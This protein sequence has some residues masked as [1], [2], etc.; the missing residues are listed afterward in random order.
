M[1]QARRA[2]IVGAGI[3][4]LAAAAS[5]ARRGWSVRVHE[6]G[7][8]LRASGAGIY[9]YE[10][11]LRV[12]EALGALGEAIEGASLAQ[13]RE[14]HDSSGNLVSVHRWGA[15]GR[16]YSITRQRL[17]DALASAA[18]AAGADI[19]LRS[20][21][22]S[23]TPAGE[24]TLESGERLTADLVVAADGVNSRL[25][26][27]LGLLARRSEMADGA[28]R[29]LIDKT[30]EERAAGDSGK[31]IETWSGTRRVLLTPCSESEIYVALTMLD[32]DEAAKR[33]P[34]DVAAWSS[35]FPHL[36]PLLARIGPEGRYDRFSYVRLKRWSAGRVAVIGDAAHA[37]PPNIGQG[38]GCAMMNALALATWLGEGRDVGEALE[39]WERKERPL[40]AHTQRFSLLMGKPTTWPRPLQR[41][42]FNL[43]G[44]SR[45]M[46]EMRSRTARH[47]P[48]GTV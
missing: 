44:R 14:V 36:A 48:T 45:F 27:G 30:A 19:V 34:I 35:W 26:D 2:E 41:G 32:R 43:V 15:T 20:A 10:N 12:L 22:V 24:L 38:G 13:T 33:V 31:T 11:G 42:F 4:G 9:V 8:E 21:G 7:P 40:T 25:R 47:I 17:I 16:V 39:E 46:G 28:I 18:R 5:L 6:R 29:V 23:A 1:N 37:M 3:G